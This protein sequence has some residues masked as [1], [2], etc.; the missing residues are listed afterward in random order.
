MSNSAEFVDFV[1]EALAPL[2]PVVV[3]RMFGGAAL[4][5]GGLTFALVLD[6]TLWLKSDAE[7]IAD[8]AAEGCPPFTYQT[9]QG[10]RVLTSYRR[11]PERLLDDGEELAAWARGALATARRVA[12]AKKPAASRRREKA[13]ERRTTGAPPSGTGRLRRR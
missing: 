2:G 13:A 1:Q 8:F 6:D 11:A 7:T 9:R 10:R 4:S 5:C 3:R 12:A